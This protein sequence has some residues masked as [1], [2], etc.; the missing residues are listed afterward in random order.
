MTDYAIRYMRVPVSKLT[1]KRFATS[2]RLVMGPQEVGEYT[3]DG[4]FLLTDG[5]SDQFISYPQ[6]EGLRT[7]HTGRLQPYTA[8]VMKAC[9]LLVEYCAATN[10]SDDDRNWQAWLDALEEVNRAVPLRTYA[11][12]KKYFQEFLAA[13][14]QLSLPAQ[15][16]LVQMHGLQEDNLA[17]RSRVKELEQLNRSLLEALQSPEDAAAMRRLSVALAGRVLSLSGEQ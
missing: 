14:Q 8:S 7:C 9:I 13:S 1:F 10:V 12:Q 5:S 4:L 6:D 3:H 2:L 11:Y 17:L 15:E 16:L